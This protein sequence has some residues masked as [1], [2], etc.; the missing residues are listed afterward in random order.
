MTDTLSDSAHVMAAAAK[1]DPRITVSDVVDM[2]QAETA[3]RD[4]AERII[5]D[6]AR[7]AVSTLSPTSSTSRPRVR[8]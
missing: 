7:A 1:A 2:M 6:R 3:L 4:W 8:S 5:F